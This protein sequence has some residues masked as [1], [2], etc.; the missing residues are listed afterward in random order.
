MN[1]K[2]PL[3][4]ITI[5]TKNE[6]EN[7]VNCLESI[8]KQSYPQEEIEIIVVDNNSRDK[9]KE[10]AK[11]YTKNVFNKGPERSAQRNFGMLKKSQGKYLVF[12]DADMILAPVLIEKAIEKLERTNSAALYIPEIV[13]GKSFFSHVRRF[14]RSF[15]NGTV[16]DCVR[17]IRKDIFEKV[18]GFDMSLTG[19][20]DWDLDKKIRIKG[21]TRLLNKKGAVIFHNENEFNLKNYLSKKNYYSQTFKDYIKKWG[22]NDADIKKQFGFWY[23]YF[24]VF[25]ENGKW[26]KLIRQPILSLSMYFLRIAVGINYL[27]K[28]R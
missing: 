3:V 19:P 13:L 23:R 6:E 25:L 15:Y 20:E 17:M 1:K 2:S 11:K 21:E 14:E 27:W 4:S 26:K 28:K 18:K 5:I 8:K 10:I 12:L 7:I 9:T 16:I 22:E 24:G